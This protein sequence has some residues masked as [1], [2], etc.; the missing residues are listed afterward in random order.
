M[1]QKVG[2]VRVSTK[3]Q[4]DDRQLEIMK[5]Q[6]VEKIFKEKVSGKSTTDRPEFQKMMDYVREGDTLTV[7][8]YSRLARS[9]RDLLNI[10]DG[11]NKKGVNLISVKEQIDTTTPTGKLLFTIMAGIS[12]FEREIMLQR[13]GEGIVEAKK[14]GTVFGRP[15]VEYPTDFLKVYDKWKANEITGVQAMT[16]LEL[17]RAT[18]YRLVAKHEGREVK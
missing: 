4:H 6:G 1:G 3:G 12:E 11:L 5:E 16:E 14:K 8:S 17:T 10:V 15:K 9:T 2:Y 7:E 18:F 13:Q